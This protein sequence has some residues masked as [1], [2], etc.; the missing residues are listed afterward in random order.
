VPGVWTT[1]RPQ[2][3][4]A[5]A[6]KQ[7]PQ[8]RR[9]GRIKD[10]RGRKVTQ[11]DPVSV[12]YSCYRRF[13]DALRLDRCYW[14]S[15]GRWFESSRPES[16]KFFPETILRIPPLVAW[17]GLRAFRGHLATICASRPPDS[18]P[19]W[20]LTDPRTRLERFTTNQ[21]VPGTRCRACTSTPPSCENDA[22]R[23]RIKNVTLGLSRR[24]PGRHEL[25][26][27]S[28]GRLLRVSFEPV[29]FLP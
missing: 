2:E 18:P 5:M 23:R 6:E 8:P 26:S 19:E 27:S 12:V 28:V 15:R 9:A 20:R 4:R 17:E 1:P 21:E 13:L 10:A 24:A 14:G 7:A 16:R 29:Q 3:V 25:D 22:R 11:L